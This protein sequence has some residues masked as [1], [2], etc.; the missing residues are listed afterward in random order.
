[1]RPRHRLEAEVIRDTMLA[2]SGSLDPTAFGPGTLD[3]QSKRRSIYF[4]VKRSK[5]LPMMQVFD[6][7]DAL[8]SLGE[9]PTTTIGPQA[10]MLLNN[11][12]IRT[13]AKSFARQIA[14]DGKA[15]IE[16]A[17]RAGYLSAI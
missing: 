5:I 7:P 11:P 10:L 15:S 3:E 8:V 4:T 13:Y 16:D 12:N 14:Q 9:R 17:V 2:V 1:R 6:A